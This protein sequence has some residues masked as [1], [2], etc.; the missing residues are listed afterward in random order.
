MSLL[1]IVFFSNSSLADS[2][3]NRKSV[4]INVVDEPLNQVMERISEISG[5]E[6]VFDEEWENVPVSL[7]IENES[8]DRALKRVLANLNHALVWNEEERKIKI[9]ISGKTG[10]ARS[11][12]S[13]S[14][15]PLS[16]RSPGTDMGFDSSSYDRT[17]SYSM[18]SESVEGSERIDR[19]PGI[20]SQQQ[21]PS[22]SITGGETRFEQA[23]S[24]ID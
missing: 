10:S 22:V 12:S 7:S 14:S 18:P 2:D 16:E 1:T 23:S 9:F 24:T 5:Y 4:T 17:P 3:P 21:G 6:I 13:Y 19:L 20:S 8:L 11:K 15:R